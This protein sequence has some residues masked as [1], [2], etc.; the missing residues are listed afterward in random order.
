MHWCRPMESRLAKK[1]LLTT[2]S[3]CLASVGQ[4][5]MYEVGAVLSVIGLW[6]SAGRG[7]AS[8]RVRKAPWFPGTHEDP[9]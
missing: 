5:F 4:V 1:L 7:T 8:D 3:P 9:E 6:V 2:C